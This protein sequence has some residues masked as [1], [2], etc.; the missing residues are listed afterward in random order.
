ML[1]IAAVDPQRDKAQRHHGHAK[2]QRLVPRERKQHDGHARPDGEAERLTQAVVP[3]PFAKTRRRRNVGGCR[4]GR[5]RHGAEPR[6][7]HR[8]QNSLRFQSRKRYNPRRA[9]EQEHGTADYETAPRTPVD[10][11]SNRNAR[12]R[13]RNRELQNERARIRV[14]PA[15]QR[16]VNRRPVVKALNAYER[17]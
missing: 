9:D 13:R 14:A 16:H 15:E 1:L 10:H 7:L 6:A 12:N 17:K 8:A 3:E 4:R 2:E 5:R 11:A